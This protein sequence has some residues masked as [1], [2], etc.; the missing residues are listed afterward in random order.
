MK[1][2]SFEKRTLFFMSSMTKN[3]PDMRVLLTCF[4]LVAHISFSQSQE[5]RG[6]VTPSP[7]LSSRLFNTQT[8]KY[9]T[10]EEVLK[11]KKE[12]PNFRYEPVYDVAGRLEKYLFDPTEPYKVVRRNP[13]LQPKVGE[14]FPDFIFQTT[15]EKELTPS[16]IQG[17]WTLLFFKNSLSTLNQPQFDKLLED[18]KT[19]SEE[20]SIEALAIFAYDDP[21]ESVIENQPIDGVKNGNGFFQRFHLTAMPTVYLIDPTG[22]IEAKF[23][24]IKRIDFLGYLKK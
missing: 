20:F 22:R 15:K 6:Y 19:A 3:F 13:D 16:T 11:L 23:E 9:L 5:L 8:G 21:I 18:L 4:L 17:K 1:P 2:E 12:I 14:L 24:G 10:E 7:D